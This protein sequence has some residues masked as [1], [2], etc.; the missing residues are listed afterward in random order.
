VTQ[1]EFC[2]G[3]TIKYIELWSRGAY[4]GCTG[5]IDFSD[6]SALWI[7]DDVVGVIKGNKIDLDAEEE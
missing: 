1:T 5:R 2:K 3:K 4:E 7:G 6:G